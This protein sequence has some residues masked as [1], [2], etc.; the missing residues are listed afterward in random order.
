MSE[1]NFVRGE[2][3]LYRGAANAIITPAEYGLSQFAFNQLMPLVGLA[4]REAIGGRLVVTS[5]RVLFEAHAV[6]RVKGILSTPLPVIQEMRRCRFGL[7]I[8]LDFITPVSKQRYVTWSR[9]KIISAV[10]QAQADFGPDQE[11]QLALLRGLLDGFEVNQSAESLNLAAREIFGITGVVPK[12]L[13]LIG[14]LNHLRPAD[15][16]L[17]PRPDAPVD[18]APWPRPDAE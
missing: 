17:S 18:Q 13:E 7:G 3:Q 5:I 12:P 8:G 15:P 2:R 16:K 4:G 9:S 11:A 6:N 10:N 14:L 1:I